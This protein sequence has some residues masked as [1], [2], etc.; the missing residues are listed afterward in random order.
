MSNCFRCIKAQA[1]TQSD[2]YLYSLSTRR[3]DSPAHPATLARIS[4]KGSRKIHRLLFDRRCG[5]LFLQS[6]QLATPAVETTQTDRRYSRAYLNSP[7]THSPL[8]TETSL[9]GCA[10]MPCRASPPTLPRTSLRPSCSARTSPLEESI[11]Q[12]WI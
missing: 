8:S 11:S 2:Q 6:E 10:K 9:P 5:R 4:T 3:K 7:L 12:I 1:D